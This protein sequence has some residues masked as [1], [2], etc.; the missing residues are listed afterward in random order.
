MRV[1]KLFIFLCIFF[2]FQAKGQLVDENKLKWHEVPT[3]INKKRLTFTSTTGV[4]GYTIAMFGLYHLWYKDYPK[5]SF[6][7]FN[8]NKEWLQMDKCGHATTSYY[9]GY[10]AMKSISWTGLNK[11]KSLWYGSMFSLAFLTTIEVFDGFSAQWGFSLGDMIANLSGSTLLIGQEYL[12]QKQIIKLK[13]SAQ[14]SPYA[15]YRPNILGN[16]TIE[17][18][19]KDYNGQTYWFSINLKSCINH[20]S[21]PSWLNLALGYSANGMISGHENLTILPNIERY[22]QYLVSFDI[23]LTEIKTKSPFLN[24]FLT[25][26]GFIKIPFPALEYNKMNGMKGHWIYF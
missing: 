8:D 16:N 14:H 13:F 9:V 15:K 20:S 26:F 4:G 23:D 22:R 7:F 19:L 12:F 5:Q 24:T 21:I 25:T 10:L 1:T 3:E 11:N 6:Q 17:R 2:S 18:L